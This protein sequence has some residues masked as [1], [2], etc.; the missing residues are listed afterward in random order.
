LQILKIKVA[1]MNG[2][3]LDRLENFLKGKEFTGTI[4]Q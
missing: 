1:V 2:K 4:I 3:Y